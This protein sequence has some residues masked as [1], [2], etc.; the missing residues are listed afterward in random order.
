MIEMKYG[1]KDAVAPEDCVDE[2]S[3]PAGNAPFPDAQTAQDHLR[4]VFYRMGFGDE[5][6]VALSGAHT[7]GRA[8]KV[9]VCLESLRLSVASVDAMY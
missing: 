4:N 9:G 7:L 5:G 2:G 3:L 1:R 8:F 6:I